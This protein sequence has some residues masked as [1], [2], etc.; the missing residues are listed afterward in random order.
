MESGEVEEEGGHRKAE[1]T[2]PVVVDWVTVE[3][4]AEDKAKDTSRE[5]GRGTLEESLNGPDLRQGA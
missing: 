2:D 5:A 4:K 1:S 3:N